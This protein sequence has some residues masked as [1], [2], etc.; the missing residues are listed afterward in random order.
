MAQR[1]HGRLRAAGPGAPDRLGEMGAAHRRRLR[2]GLAVLPGPVRRLAVRPGDA[3][4]G[5]DAAVAPGLCLVG[6]RTARPL[7]AP[8]LSGA[9]GGAPGGG[10]GVLAGDRPAPRLAG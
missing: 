10:P 4:H 9:A 6:A 2:P 3:L 5:A 8:D 1:Q 7:P